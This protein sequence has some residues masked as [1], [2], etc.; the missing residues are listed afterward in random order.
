MSQ[1]RTK[2]KINVRR[3]LVS[4]AVVIGL[5][6]GFIV[7]VGGGENAPT[8]LYA[9]A[10]APCYTG[11]GN[12][13]TPVPYS[14]PLS[15]AQITAFTAKAPQVAQGDYLWDLSY[16]KSIAGRRVAFQAYIRPEAFD[17][18]KD[19]E[20]FKK[21][22]ITY[23]PANYVPWNEGATAQRMIADTNG[24]PE[25]ERILL[26]FRDSDRP[27]EADNFLLVYG[28][29]SDVSTS[30][31]PGSS[32]PYNRAVVT[33]GDWEPLSAAEVIEPAVAIARPPFAT[34]RDALA[35]SLKGVDFS[36]SQTRVKLSLLYDGAGAGEYNTEA[37]RIVQG[38]GVPLDQK[39]PTDIPIDDN[40]Q[41]GGSDLVPNQPRPVT[42]F[43]P[44]IQNPTS[45]RLRLELPDP[46]GVKEDSIVLTLTPR[47]VR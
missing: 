42:L 16:Y 34:R 45:S 6:I 38:Q 2:Y 15:G 22:G 21:D 8:V 13:Q 35:I 25:D 46:T 36:P 27:T 40:S 29:V 20:L 43:F 41:L 44:G 11:C 26:G 5:V 9:P 47:D 23:I 1:R 4:L 3:L 19:D 31:N 30:I 32:S 37:V 12:G 17:A 7:V 39:L 18:R 24:A 14:F 28:Y 33:V 10:A